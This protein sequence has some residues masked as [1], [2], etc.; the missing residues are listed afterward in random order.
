MNKRILIIIGSL[1][2]VLAL[3]AQR[4][5]IDSSADSAIHAATVASVG[6]ATFDLFPVLNPWLQSTNPAGLYFNPRVN[7]GDISLNHK[8]IN[9]D[10]KRAQEGDSLRNYFMK[11][12]SYKRIQNT[13]FFG[14]FM[15]EK[16]YER[17]CNYTLVNNPYRHTPY[18]LIDTMGRNDIYD[19]EFF[20]MTGEL[21]TP[22]GNNFAYGLSVNMDVGLSTQDRD[23]RPRNKVMNLNAAQG[24]LFSGGSVSLGLN[25]LYSYYNEDIEADIIEENVQHAFLQLQGF[26]T[27][28]SHVATSF[29]RLYKRSS[30]GGEGQLG[31]KTGG[32][33]SIFGAKFIYLQE[34]ADDGRKAGNA[35][36]SYIKNDSEL[37][38]NQIKIFNISTYSHDRFHHHLDAAYSVQT[39]LGA[40]MLQRLEQVGEAGAV[41]WVEYGAEEKYGA[42][43]SNLDL[44]YTFLYMKDRFLPSLEIRLG[45]AREGKEHGYDLPYMSEEYSNRRWSTGVKKI[46]YPGKNELSVG[47]GVSFKKNL[48]GSLQ[49]DN[50]NFITE[51]LLYPDFEY[52]TQNTTAYW[53][54]FSIARQMNRFFDKFFARVY[55]GTVQAEN[56]TK[57]QQIQINTGLIF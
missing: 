52:Y 49:V 8:M 53:L 29:Y 42:T 2:Q 32:L 47:G 35:S 17:N 16:S 28:T 36:W 23:P 41:D 48:E 46:F 7:I 13:A 3:C 6:T 20:N 15:Y 5:D 50:E 33:N 14:S 40:E 12:S 24:V 44:G 19:R 43:L 9:R 25:M 54:Q 1:V 56:E 10:Y 45:Y 27:Y 38:G 4:T 18:L 30:Y 37:K 57:Q 55:L 26:N 11:T 22:L 34:T 51:I 21:S 31:V 39:M